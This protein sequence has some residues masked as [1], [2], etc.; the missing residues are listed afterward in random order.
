M[1][2]DGEIAY[3]NTKDTAVKHF[4][5]AATYAMEKGEEWVKIM[6]EVAGDVRGKGME[7][8]EQSGEVSVC[9]RGGGVMFS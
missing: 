2:H 9:A 3:N 1:M 8:V 4:N 5:V 7:I 6:Q